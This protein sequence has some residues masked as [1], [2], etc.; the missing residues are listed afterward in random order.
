MPSQ[1]YP[2]LLYTS[3]E[4]LC[5]SPGQ[6]KWPAKERSRDVLVTAIDRKTLARARMFMFVNVMCMSV[7]NIIERVALSSVPPIAV[8]S[9]E[10]WINAI[11]SLVPVSYTHLD[12]YK[13]QSLQLATSLRRGTCRAAAATRCH[14]RTMA[15]S[16]G[17]P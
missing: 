13:R 1:A 2:C 3:Q 6:G 5:S 4:H 10:V 11:A 12:V 16:R 8:T 7:S 14:R 9:I 15:C 17:H